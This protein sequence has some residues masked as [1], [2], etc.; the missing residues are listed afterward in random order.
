MIRH[1]GLVVTELTVWPDVAALR[2]L[3]DGV[4]RR[5]DLRSAGP[6]APVVAA[7]RAT[8]PAP[9]AKLSVGEGRDAP[10][11]GTTQ[12]TSAILPGAPPA[13]HSGT[14]H[15]TGHGGGRDRGPR[16]SGH[17]KGRKR[18]QVPKAPLPRKVRRVRA[19]L[20]GLAMLT[21]AGLLVTYVVQGVKRTKDVAA[22]A[23][24]PAASS[25]PGTGPARGTGTPAA[26]SSASSAPTP[27]PSATPSFDP[28]TSSYTIPNTVLFALNSARLLPDARN[29]LDQVVEG[30]L[31]DKRYGRIIVTGY[32]DSS[33]GLAL[34]LSLS[35]QRAK[36]VAVYLQGK[37][38]D[39][40]VLAYVGLGPENPRAPNDSPEHMAL[41]RRVEIKVPAPRG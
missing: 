3:S 23:S 15:G 27:T 4:A 26:S 17:E 10:A 5:I 13:P 28:R 37:L 29:A 1:D 40:F 39:H 31:H 34:N 16:G 32:T 41:N 30:V 6:A 9:E 24:T 19:V 7:L 38:D 25:T 14:G 2:E 12:I 33:G 20:A 11:S 18:S 8:I 36:A 22:A 21:A 35:E